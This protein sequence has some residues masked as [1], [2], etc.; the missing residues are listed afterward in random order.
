[1]PEKTRDLVYSGSRSEQG[2]SLLAKRAC[3]SQNIL[4][5]GKPILAFMGP[6]TMRAMKELIQQEQD[7]SCMQG[8]VRYEVR[9][10]VDYV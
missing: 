3:V 8:T 2:K 10:Q 9:W 4:M 1:M 7:C 6:R 5:N